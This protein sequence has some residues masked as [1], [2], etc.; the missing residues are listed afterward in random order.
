MHCT[1]K[2]LVIWFE[3]IL[4]YR[5]KS[6]SGLTK[7]PNWWEFLLKACAPGGIK[8]GGGSARLHAISI[9]PPFPD[10]RLLHNPEQ[11]GKI[12]KVPH[13]RKVSCMNKWWNENV[14]HPN[15]K[16]PCMNICEKIHFHASKFHFNACKVHFMHVNFM[17]MHANETILHAISCHD[18]PCMK[19]SVRAHPT[20]SWLGRSGTCLFVHVLSCCHLVPNCLALIQQ[21]RSCFASVPAAEQIR[22]WTRAILQQQRGLGLM[23][24]F[25]ICPAGVYESPQLIS[26]WSMLET[27]HTSPGT[28]ALLT[29]RSAIFWLPG[30]SEKVRGVGENR[31]RFFSEVNK[32]IFY[33]VCM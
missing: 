15:K 5:V 2:K 11:N 31:L 18:F 9:P 12:R 30:E 26:I 33:S 6:K 25:L 21:M 17:F 32:V 16:F 23:S 8:R 1:G 24:F 19:P 7:Y 22:T 13:V 20:C 3:L 27:T 28:L 29:F 4:S 10:P 14:M